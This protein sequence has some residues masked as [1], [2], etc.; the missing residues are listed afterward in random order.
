LKASEAAPTRKRL[1]SPIDSQRSGFLRRCRNRVDPS[2]LG[3]PPSRR[4]RTTGLRREDVAALSGVSVSWYTWLE[5]GRD[6]RVS[7]EVLER[8]CVTLRLNPD[9]R[10]YLFSLVQQRAPR[11]QEGELEEAPADVVRLIQSIGIPAVVMNL[12]W[13]I[14]A[15]NP[16]SAAIYGDYGKL[17][18]PERNLLHLVLVRP[19]QHNDSVESERMARHLIARLRFDYSKHGDDPRFEA[20][21]RLLEA[22]SPVFRRLWSVPEFSL[23]ALGR[24]N[25][26]SERYGDVT[27]EHI[28]VIPDG[29]PGIRIGTSVPASPEA[30]RAIAHA[31]AELAKN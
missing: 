21:I 30:T 10:V 7:D 1:R 27:F 26:K 9:E 6:M 15:W 8:L 19:L 18:P 13:D 28:S 22:A 12:R 29:H 3:L 2:D 20:L 23:R 14:L 5:Q 17:P 24:F 31:S 16:L 11:P 4:K 25:F